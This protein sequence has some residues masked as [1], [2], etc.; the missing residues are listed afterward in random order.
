LKYRLKRKIIFIPPIGPDRK[1]KY[2]G[3]HSVFHLII[4]VHQEAP[5]PW[6]RVFVYA[7]DGHAFRVAYNSSFYERLTSRTF[8]TV[9]ASFLMLHHYRTS[10]VMYRMEPIVKLFDYVKGK[11]V[12]HVT[13]PKTERCLRWQKGGQNSNPLITV[14]SNL[15]AIRQP[16]LDIELLGHI[17]KINLY[18]STR[19]QI[20]D[21]KVVELHLLP[22]GNVVWH[23]QLY[24]HRFYFE[25]TRESDV[26]FM[27]DYSKRHALGFVV[28]NNITHD[29]IGQPWRSPLF[30]GA[31]GIIT[32]SRTG[33]LLN[34]DH[35]GLHTRLGMFTIGCF[36]GEGLSFDSH[37][38]VNKFEIYIEGS[39]PES[40][41]PDK[42][43]IDQLS[44]NI[45]KIHGYKGK[46]K[47][48]ISAVVHMYT[49]MV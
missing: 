12:G 19:K 49:E 25:F 31:F 4:T 21:E 14:D 7:P 36:P 24:C 10:G 28:F 32:L 17:V 2:F 44:L 30:T 46:Q 26:V 5:V 47:N 35:L 8:M 34:Y 45:F 3:F 6:K 1:Y 23:Y 13:I 29:P 48:S 22:G 41:K 9:A 18:N 27:L 33:A 40:F 16:L 37:G 42:T 43:Q 15:Y 20:G 38:A 39:S 11:V